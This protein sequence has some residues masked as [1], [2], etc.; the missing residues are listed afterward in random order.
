MYAVGS[1]LLGLAP[2]DCHFVDDD[3][4]WCPPRST[5]AIDNNLY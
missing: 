4:S 1:D 2:T 3:P 5:S